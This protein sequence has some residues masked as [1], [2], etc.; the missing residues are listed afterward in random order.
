VW[1]ASA[2]L[3]LIGTLA[4][5]L[6]GAF[7]SSLLTMFASAVIGAC[8]LPRNALPALALWLLVLIPVPFMDSP[9]LLGQY[10]TPTVL[11][12]AIW[13]IRLALAQRM[14]LLLR[15]PIRGWL[16]IAPFFVLLLASAL[17]SER[18]DL[19]LA[20][21][22]VVI[23][24]VV[25][26]ALL[27]QI[28]LDDVWPT[29]RWTFAGIGLF[30]GVL[31][32]ADFFIH[33]N[34][35]TGLFRY[36]V[37]NET[38]SV[39]RTKTSLG[40]PLT[41]STVA[42]VALGVCLFPSGG[43]RRWPYWICAVGALVALILSV[44]RASVFAVG[45]A[46]II[47]ALSAHPSTRQS[48]AR[49]RVRLISVL[50]AAALSAAVAWSPLLRRR[51]EASEAISSAANRSNTLDNAMNLIAERPML[52][53]GP[54]TSPEVY[55]ARYHEPLESSAFQLLVSMGIPAFLF[56]SVGLGIIVTVAMRRSRAGVAAGIAAFYVSAIGFNIVDVSPAFLALT[57][58]LIA[59]AVMPRPE[60]PQQIE[61]R[62]EL[63][64]RT[65]GHPASARRLTPR[66]RRITQ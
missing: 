24:C 43:I 3:L 9:R 5:A 17:G 29:V 27:G 35:W 11:V 48:V 23:V 16:I 50:I 57:A 44:S 41:T 6:Y 40:H 18:I 63:P 1:S 34:P 31:A 60:R 59:C 14:T 10:F 38:W 61:S 39:F 21:V 28:S 32:A 7:V 42:S 30:L 37:R 52:G 33:F 45:F 49:G 55:S 19:T 12:I 46:A 25:A 56:F 62:P 54:G 53:F 22:A 15:M 58:P 26:P 4:L 66:D 47:G 64:D 36:V 2:I 13:M 8:L 20:W 51:N 65:G